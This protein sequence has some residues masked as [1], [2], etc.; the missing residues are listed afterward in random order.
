MKICIVGG[1]SAGWMTATTLVR[2]LEDDITLVESPSINTIGVG[3]STLG[4]IRDWINLV[5]INDSEN[6]FI[7]ETGASLKHSIKFTNWLKNDSG[8]FHYPFLQ[9][10]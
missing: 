2:L 9:M 1:G 5:G 6:D 8:S 10:L 3:E 4:H 7:R